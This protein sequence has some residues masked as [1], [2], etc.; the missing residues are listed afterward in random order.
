MATT[1]VAAVA[2]R[3]D[4]FLLLPSKNDHTNFFPSVPLSCSWRASRNP[5]RS[6]T[7][8]CRGPEAPGPQGPHTEP[9]LRGFIHNAGHTGPRGLGPRVEDSSARSGPDGISLLDSRRSSS[10]ARS[11]YEYTEGR[12]FAY[13]INSHRA[14]YR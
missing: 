8:S 14:I 5:S 2:G 3:G 13:C 6:H 7:R 4:A 11:N 9:A 12:H 1:V 10:F